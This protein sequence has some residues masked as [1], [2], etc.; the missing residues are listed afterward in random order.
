MQKSRQ[1]FDV[2]LSSQRYTRVKEYIENEPGIKS[3]TDFGCGN[4]RFV[5]WL[6]QIISLNRIVCVDSDY[7]LLEYEMDNCYFKPGLCEALFGRGVGASGDLTIGIYHG[8]VVIPDNRLKS[9]CIVMIETIEHMSLACVEQATRVIFGFYKPKMVIV[10]TPNSEFNHLL[11]DDDELITKFRHSDH[12]FEWNRDEFRQWANFIIN[13]YPYSVQYDGVGSLPHSDPY[14]PCTQIAVFRCELPE[15]LE[16]LEPEFESFDL[17][18][19]KL[20][21]K[22]NLQDHGMER[23][24]N[25]V[26][27][28][29]EYTI[30]LGPPRQEPEKSVEQCEEFQWD[31]TS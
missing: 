26:S 25:E 29:V 19:N 20:S 18:L 5:L 10:T 8:D 21:V 7:S 9:E 24:K 23:R 16:S 27:K 6:K 1:V 2:P 22:D 11:R 12:K 3:V 4:G 13:N 17:L 31:L 15:Y 14:G 30:P 28:I